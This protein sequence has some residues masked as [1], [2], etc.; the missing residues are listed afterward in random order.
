MDL[1]QSYSPLI[2]PFLSDLVTKI[3]PEPFFRQIISGVV[4]NVQKESGQT[5][6]CI[7][8][9]RVRSSYL[10]CDTWNLRLFP[11]ATAAWYLSAFAEFCM[12]VGVLHAEVQ[13]HLCE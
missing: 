6:A 2:A 7:F 4:F 12:P 3:R 5:H 1:N 8:N 11:P 9:T 10:L 13:P